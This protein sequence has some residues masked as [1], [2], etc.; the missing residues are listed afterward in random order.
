MCTCDGHSEKQHIMQT[1]YGPRWKKRSERKRKEGRRFQGD[2]RS[3][4]SLLEITVEV[5]AAQVRQTSIPRMEAYHDGSEE[6][7][8][9]NGDHADR[10][11]MDGRVEDLVAPSWR[12]QRKIILNNIYYYYNLL[13]LVNVY[14][15]ER[16]EKALLCRG[17]RTKLREH[18]S[19]PHKQQKP[20]QHIP[21]RWSHI[22]RPLTEV[23]EATH[24]SAGF[25]GFTASS[26]MFLVK[27]RL[28]DVWKSQGPTLKH[29]TAAL[30][31]FN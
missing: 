24:I 17:W 22:N 2:R 13:L 1:F 7:S 18:L 25:L 12:E 6:V 8:I 30:H 5:S 27:P 11:Q 3:H 4:E 20:L 28:K 29:G 9:I 26:F 23:I 31:D 19:E 15:K 16:L 14:K 21:S 10:A